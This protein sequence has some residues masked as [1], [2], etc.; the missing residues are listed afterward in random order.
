MPDQEFVYDVFLSHAGEDTSWCETLAARLRNEGVRVW[1]D[2]WEL[3]PGDNLLA[4]IN[5]GLAKSRKMIAVWSAHYFRDGKVWTL[6]ESFSQLHGDPLSQDRP[7]IPLL[8]E[9]CAILPTFRNIL[10]I[11]FR[12]EVDFDLRFR[13]LLQALDLPR[14]EFEQEKEVVLEKGV[15]GLDISRQGRVTYKKGKRFEDE[16]ATLYRLPGF[17]VKQG[18]Q[19]SGVQIDLQIQ[20]KIGGLLT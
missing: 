15:L 12:N 20:Q 8:I 6:V 3:Q 14:R 7:I 19:L 17:E 5:D 11:D 9:D 13:Q 4:R 10:S 18:A 1:F 16:V 2:Q